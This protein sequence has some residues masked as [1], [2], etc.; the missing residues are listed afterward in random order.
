[1]LYEKAF[2]ATRNPEALF[3]RTLIKQP[4]Q[5]G[6][7]GDVKM[8]ETADGEEYLDFN[9]RQ[10]K[11]R[12]CSDCCDIRAMRPKIF[13]TEGSEN[14]SVVVYKLYAQARPEKMNEA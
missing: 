12:T 7:W 2:L 3:K 11:R 10:T 8:K 4:K 6:L 14:D 1:M 9:E 13:V 5:F